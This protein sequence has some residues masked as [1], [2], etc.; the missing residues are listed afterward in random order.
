MSSLLSPVVPHTSGHM[1]IEQERT[2][3]IFANHRDM[4]RFRDERDPGFRRII[5][6]VAEFAAAALKGVVGESRE[7]ST[8]EEPLVELLVEPEELDITSWRADDP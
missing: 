7:R 3:T 2:G 5:N 1:G 6:V 4:C 8:V